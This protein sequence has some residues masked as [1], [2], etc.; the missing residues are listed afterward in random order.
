MPTYCFKCSTCG[1][2]KEVVRSMQ[3]SDLPEVCKCSKQMERDFIAEHGSVR[4]DY[5]DPIISDSMAF[6]AADIDEHRRRFPDVDIIVEGRSARPV[7]RNLNQK[8]RYLKGRK[9][10]D[11]NSFV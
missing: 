6:D 4:G 10:V 11:C 8:R 3:D 2:R 1:G 9:W 5:N 7:L